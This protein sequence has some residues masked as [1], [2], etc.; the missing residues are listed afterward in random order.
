MDYKTLFEKQGEYGVVTGFTLPIYTVEG[1]P[2]AT[3]DE[4]V[5][6]ENGFRG[7]VISVNK[8]QL[9]VLSLSNITLNNNDKVVRSGERLQIGVS[10]NVLGHIV[11]PLLENLL[12]DQAPLVY[13]DIKRPL[14]VSPLG[15]NRRSLV[16]RPLRT[17]VK[18]VDFLVPLGKG[19]REL[20][21]GD[22]KTGKT[23]VALSAA[24]AQVAEKAVVVYCAI[25][26]KLTDVLETW[27]YF[28]KTGIAKRSLLV[29]STAEDSPGLIYLTPFTAFTIAEYFRDMGTDVLVILD[30]LTNH[31]KAFREV[32]LKAKAFPGRE[33]YPADIFS[34]HAK[35][36]ERAGSFTDAKKS[37]VAIS[38]LAIAET[39][40]GDISSY[41]T[42]NL[43]GM[44]DGH[45][46]YD[47][48]LFGLGQRPAVNVG[49]SVTRVGK[50]TCTPLKRQ[51]TE[52][53]GQRLS[54][55]NA[56]K[57]YTHFGSELTTEV[58]AKLLQGELINAYL[59]Q[60]FLELVPEVEAHT[61]FA[62]ILNGY[63][64]NVDE[65]V[66]KLEQLKKDIAEA[67][68]T[69]TLAKLMIE[70]NDLETFLE[71]VKKVKI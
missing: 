12:A 7:M 58:K 34:L 48:H 31:A 30:D 38:C 19:Q 6:G 33:S 25:G 68:L 50:Q 39:V 29:A 69:N 41:I 24:R 32:Y 60:D 27:S 11:T 59:Q 71:A 40:E 28:Q 54:T 3:L 63:F 37:E 17:G 47:A 2:G 23:N 44:T 9:K 62:L 51:L 20:V 52:T 65:L 55:Y 64:A 1:L 66:L 57:N 35:L 67:A 56:L 21:L 43:M 70:S 49:L 10:E 61:V 4:E 5:L 15:I 36:L 26:K 46:Y 13:S 22:R 53:L 42:T 16:R 18:V 14:D 45:I 8:N